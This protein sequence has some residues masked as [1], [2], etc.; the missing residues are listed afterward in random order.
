MGNMVTGRNPATRLPK[1]PPHSTVRDWGYY[2]VL[3]EG[4]GYKIKRLVVMPGKGT[5][6]QYHRC[7]SEYWVVKSG[8]A[9]IEH[10]NS[11][12]QLQPQESAYIPVGDWHRLSNPGSA[13]LVVIEV[14][15]GD[16]LCER[17]IVRH[18][19]LQRH[20]AYTPRLPERVG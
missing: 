5:S 14:Q 19:E 15:C 7:R 4:R 3:G 20:T 13:P 10:E 12:F 2:T 8:V 6:L 18:D 16:R 9:A 11:H 1:S 17:D